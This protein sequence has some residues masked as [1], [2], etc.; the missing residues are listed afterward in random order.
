MATI[1]T[2][3]QELKRFS[4]LVERMIQ[5]QFRYFKHG[6]KHAAFIEMRNIEKLVLQD[7]ER[8]KAGQIIP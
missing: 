5:A 7:I 8:Y 6:R 2:A 1:T 3:E 4:D